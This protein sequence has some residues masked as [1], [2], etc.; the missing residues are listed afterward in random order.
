MAQD[1]PRRVLV[2]ATGSVASVKLP[3]LVQQLLAVQTPQV[4]AGRHGVGA[5]TLKISPPELVRALYPLLACSQ[6]MYVHQRYLFNYLFIYIF[7][8]L[9]KFVF[10]CFYALQK[11]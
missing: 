8:L 6:R 1:R 2:G 5:G 3:E 10:C 9:F 11:I 7:V 4:R